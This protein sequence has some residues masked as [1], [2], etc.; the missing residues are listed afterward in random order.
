MRIGHRPKALDKK[1]R[2]M[3]SSISR[4]S[5]TTPVQG[6]SVLPRSL[7]AVRIR[8]GGPVQ[9]RLP[10]RFV[11]FP[12]HWVRRCTCCFTTASSIGTLSSRLRGARLQRNRRLQLEQDNSVY[13]V[14]FQTPF[15][16]GRRVHGALR[17]CSRPVSAVHLSLAVSSGRFPDDPD[18]D[19]PRFEPTKPK[20][21]PR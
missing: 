14:A 19:S 10:S 2:S 1:S 17:D 11:Q 8:R 12:A 3:T 21:S 15:P 6:I 13:S 9:H 16:D 5:A 18:R 20:S 7:W 4:S